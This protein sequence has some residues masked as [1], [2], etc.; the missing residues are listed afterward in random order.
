M[1]VEHTN[2]WIT[3]SPA[4]CT[5]L[6][7]GQLH[8]ALP[9]ISQTSQAIRFNAGIDNTARLLRSAKLQGVVRCAWHNVQQ[10]FA[11]QQR[12]LTVSP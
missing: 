11:M 5:A 2:F 12:A 8:N 7:G 4:H 3:L 6:G 1:S 9:G 10:E